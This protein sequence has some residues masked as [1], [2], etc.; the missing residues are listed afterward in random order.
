MY[1]VFSLVETSGLRYNRN[2]YGM[3]R[4]IQKNLSACIIQNHVQILQAYEEKR[5]KL[6]PES[7]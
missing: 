3:K 1:P 2:A 5:K 7:K 6:E 4:T